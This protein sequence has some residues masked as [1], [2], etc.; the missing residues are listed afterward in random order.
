[1]ASKRLFA[2]LLASLCLLAG[3]L[4]PRT[5]PVQAAD[6]PTL[7]AR[8]ELTLSAADLPGSYRELQPSFLSVGGVPIEDRLLRRTG[9]GSGPAWV[10]NAIYQTPEPPSAAGIDRAAQNLAVVLNDIFGDD[11]ILRDWSELDAS[12]F[13]PRAA[14][15][16]FTYHDL[17]DDFDADGAFVIIARDDLVSVLALLSADGRYNVD[18]R[19]YARLVDARLRAGM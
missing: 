1:M 11:V 14:L 4:G 12:E 16:T 2:A 19:H 5:S 9:S 3:S 7:A 13:G 6:R 18:A 10:W 17:N 8:P 15:R